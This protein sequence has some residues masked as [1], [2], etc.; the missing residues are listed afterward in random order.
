MNV[1]LERD[2]ATSVLRRSRHVLPGRTP[3]FGAATLPA[4]VMITA[5][6][7]PGCATVQSTA[8]SNDCQ[9]CQRQCR[10]CQHASAP[11]A[12]AP[13]TTKT[14]RQTQFAQDSATSRD[15]QLKPVQYTQ[16][17]PPGCAAPVISGPLS[18]SEN[19]PLSHVPVY[20]HSVEMSGQ[21]PP[22]S[23]MT[24]DCARQQAELREQT[25]QLRQKMAALERRLE[26]EQQAKQQVTSS[27]QDMNGEMD[28]LSQEITYWRNETRRVEQTFEEQHQHDITALDA[29]VQLVEQ[30][31]TPE[32]ASGGSG[33]LTLPS[34]NDMQK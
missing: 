6:L 23:A 30:V 33:S 4:W 11:M 10:S 2:A 26:T 22:S 31:P 8:H 7:L 29:I 14:I 1:D 18:I 21:F 19:P 9:R 34:V 32:S 16:S 24:A 3:R 25:N 28:R 5:I 17:M 20:E 27:L 13:Q 15:G 12:A